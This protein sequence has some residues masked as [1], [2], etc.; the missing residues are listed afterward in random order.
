MD[1]FLVCLKSVEIFQ[2]FSS[3]YKLTKAPGKGGCI[4]KLLLLLRLYLNPQRGAGFVA[5]YQEL[6]VL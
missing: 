5:P 1:R 3:F 4:L 2:A 6:A